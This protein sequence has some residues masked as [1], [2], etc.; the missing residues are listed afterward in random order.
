MTTQ[1]VGDYFAFFAAVSFILGLL[2]FFRGKSK[3]SL[4]AGG[5]SAVLLAI[6]AV[7]TQRQGQPGILMGTIVSG[8]LAGRF[9][10]TFFKSKRIYPAGILGLLS[11]IGLVLGLLV[12]IK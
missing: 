9:V 8:L 7:L 3:A 1:S 10:P 4:I 12:L 2:G 5:L 11:V 6:A